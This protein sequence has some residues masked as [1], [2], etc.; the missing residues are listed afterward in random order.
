MQPESLSGNWSPRLYSL[1]FG[2]LRIKICVIL[3]VAVWTLL[4]L[5]VTYPVL[6]PYRLR[7]DY[8]TRAMLIYLSYLPKYF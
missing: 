8:V 5:R 7:Q 3:R 4:I 2:A 1:V 6:S